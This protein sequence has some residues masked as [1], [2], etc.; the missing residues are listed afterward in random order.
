MIIE[1][2]QEK[3]EELPSKIAIKAG[4]RTIS[5]RELSDYAARVA[6]AVPAGDGKPGGT[7]DDR[8]R[9]VSLLFEHGVDMI[10]AVLGVLKAG[11]AYVPLDVTY[12]V[13]RLSYMLE[14]SDSGVIVT[15]GN[16]IQTAA[17]LAAR[18][19]GKIDILN[20]DAVLGE[21]TGTTPETPL[22]VTGDSLAYILYTSGSTG[23]PKGVA[24]THRNVLYYTRNWIQRFSITESD[25]MTLFS[26]FSH[27]GSVQDMFAA[28]LTGATLYP[29]YIK[30]AY[31]TNELYGLLMKE[32]ITVWHSVP[33]LYR[34]FSNTL[35]EKNCFYDIRWVLLGG[36]PLRPHDMIFFKRHFP[37]A[38]VANV[39]GQTESS[40]CSICSLSQ[41]DIF[42]AMSLGEPLD[43]TKILLMG[44][45]GEIVRTMGA[46]EIVAA[47]DYI[48]PGYWRD[49][50]NSKDVF[51]HDDKWGRLYWTGDQGRL[52]ADGL[53]KVMGRKDFQ[54]KIRGFRVETGEIESLLL[55]YEGIKEA[56]VVVKMNE[57]LQNHLCAYIVSDKKIPAGELK[58]YL[59][60]ELPD[61]M[62]PLYLV[63]LETMP[64]TPNGKINRR[65]LPEPEETIAPESVYVAP[66]NDVEKKLVEIWQEV[67][68]VEK[69]GVD[70]N[71]LELGGHSLLVISILSKIHQEFNVELQLGAVFENPTIR[72]I[73]QLV[74][75]SEENIFSSIEPVEKKEYYLATSDQKRMFVLNRLEGINT[76]YNLP[77]IW[78]AEGELDWR[79]FEKTFQKLVD[80][81]DAFRTSFK[82]VDDELVQVIHRDV[83][84]RL[85]YIHLESRGPES[86]SALQE[87]I[88]NFCKPFDLGIAPLIRVAL[89]KLPAGGHLLLLDSHHIITDGISENICMREFFHLY[90]GKELPPLK[91]KY[92]DYSEWQNRLDSSGQ[93]K[94][95]E[96]YWL[97]TFDGEIPV[98]DLPNDY[99]R[100]AV[101]GFEGDIVGF[102]LNRNVY[103]QIN[104]LTKETGT[105]LFMV[106][107]AMF[108]VLLHK[109][110]GQED[111]IVGSIVAG[112]NHID[113]ENVVGFFVKTLALRNS[114]SPDKSFDF[115]LEELKSNVLKAF[116]NQMYPFSRLV[117][118]LKLGEDRSRN[119]LFD[120]AFVLQNT[121]MSLA[122]EY[123]GDVGL[124][125]NQK[126]YKADTS[127]FD[128]NFQAIEAADGILCCF[129]Y[130][131]ALFK[132]ET[133]E[134]MGA[135]FLTLVE[136]ILNN[137]DSEIRSLDWRILIERGMDEVREVEF[138]F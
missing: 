5:Y 2:F 79:H 70:D 92:R 97:D 17:E 46:G 71:F 137:R 107:L 65:R 125:L 21:D 9:R 67:L 73:A 109:Y 116:E 49:E 57:D 98:L 24:Q 39:Y 30:T 96:E 60:R 10:I 51:T 63:P 132:R 69:I 42:D 18:S 6:N 26:A 45:N 13:N 94:Y 120:A 130:N 106:L 95:Q 3:V 110:T 64:L 11:R 35:T 105:T 136:S 48:A 82:M 124:K 108:N 14:N 25:R 59:S 78:K 55:G 90:T 34:F 126:Q 61:Y 53:I 8:Y 4:N 66:T 123:E 16:N 41:D 37:K 133:I 75:V 100:P 89:V 83:D 138:D 7:V 19:P 20:I 101:Q 128:L 58:E 88:E 121:G 102:A 99:P 112:R 104:Q 38:H 87:I 119:P 56:V 84:F 76:A 134:L 127:L 43:E 28:L 129:Q 47:C 32:K 113:L 131:T 91:L 81:Y 74:A 29:Y 33:S 80:R 52:T 93:L 62:I 117:K 85:E 15:N 44:R 22:N 135:R 1:K 36:E 122:E 50:E 114:P 12:P 111:I 40:V 115:F 77:G 31:T 72:E 118:K 86:E 68:A 54:T 103:E 23:R 27:D